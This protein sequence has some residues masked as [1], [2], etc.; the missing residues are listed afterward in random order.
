MTEDRMR[1][2]IGQL[3][4]R[5]RAL[6]FVMLAKRARAQRDAAGGAGDA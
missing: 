1:E 5:E 6:L 3:N 4:E 2:L